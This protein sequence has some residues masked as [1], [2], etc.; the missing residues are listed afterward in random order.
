M[1]SG[2]PLLCC[3]SIEKT[4]VTS[5]TRNKVLDKISFNLYNNEIVFLCG[6]NGSGKS[7]LLNILSYEILS[8]SNMDIFFHGKLL[9]KD[10]YKKQLVYLPQ[11]VDNAIIDSLKVSEYLSLFNNTSITN[12][13]NILN[14]DWLTASILKPKKSKLIGELSFGQK[15][16]LLGIAMLSTSKEILLFDEV[17]ASMDMYNR[18]LFMILIKN[19]ILN[20]Q[21]TCLIVSHDYKYAYQNANRIFVLNSGNLFIYAPSEITYKDFIKKIDI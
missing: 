5:I 20:F 16:L 1:V 3:K 9:W 14:L 12:M 2:N 10:Y 4:Y 17:F 13:L 11:K 6:V 19:F 15:Q 8:D 7:T 18:D 21:S